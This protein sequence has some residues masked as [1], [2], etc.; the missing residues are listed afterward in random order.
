MLILNSVASVED[1]FVKRSV[2]YSD[3][4]FPTMAGVLMKREKSMFLSY[5]LLAGS[6]VLFI[7]L[8]SGLTPTACESTG[9]CCIRP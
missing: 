8:S 4:P 9:S 6:L 3:R 7:H 5:V 2:N 1:L